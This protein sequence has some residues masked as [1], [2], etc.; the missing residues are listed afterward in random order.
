MILR[1]KE[2][3]AQGRGASTDIIEATMRAY[4]EAVNRL[5]SVAA[6]REVAI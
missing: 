2:I 4:V 1:Y 3:K 6:A 5:Y